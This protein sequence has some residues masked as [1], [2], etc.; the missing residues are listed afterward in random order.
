MWRLRK[1]VRS[2]ATRVALLPG[3]LAETLGIA[4]LLPFTIS[5]IEITGATP[6][7][8]SRWMISVCRLPE[9]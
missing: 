2:S 4:H 8:V 6:E 7:R 3:T 9:R 5:E 1:A